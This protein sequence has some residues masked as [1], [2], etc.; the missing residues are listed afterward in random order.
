V[1]RNTELHRG[2][3]RDTEERE[4]VLVDKEYGTK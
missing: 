2:A 4:A 3:Q 1:K